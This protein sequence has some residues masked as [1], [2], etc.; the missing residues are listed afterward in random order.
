MAGKVLEGDIQA[1]MFVRMPFNSALG[2]TARIHSVEFAR[3]TK[4]NDICLCIESEPEQSEFF[5]GLNL[6]DEIV[7]VVLKIDTTN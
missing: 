1:G 4:G 7:E 5:R 6:A 2:V 3:G